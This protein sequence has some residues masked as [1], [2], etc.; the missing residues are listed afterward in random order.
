MRLHSSRHLLIF[1]GLMSIAL[2]ASTALGQR[3][4]GRS[5]TPGGFAEGRMMKKN[6]KE[7]GLSDEV[8]AKIDAAIEAGKENEKKL[9]E[10]SMAAIGELK[11]ILN[12]D[13]PDKKKLMAASKKVGENAAKSRKLKMESVIEMRSLLTAE[14]LEKF[15][16]LRKKALSRR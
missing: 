15:M 11:E 7:I 6:A 8:V 16:E 12:E 14:Q 13:L 3:R 10:D 1:C 9:R 4:G 5:N 2:L